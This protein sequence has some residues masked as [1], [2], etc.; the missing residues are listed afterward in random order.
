[1]TLVAGET[2]NAT[3]I[4][5]KF[6]HQKNWGGEYS[7]ETLTNESD[8]VFI[9]DTTNGRDSGNLGLVEGKSFEEG[10]TYV[11][12]VDVTQ[13]RDNAVLTIEKM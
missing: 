7:P 5:F 3:T 1:M 2:I 11:F 6:W 13:G 10:K 4:N 9:G 12:T 8:L